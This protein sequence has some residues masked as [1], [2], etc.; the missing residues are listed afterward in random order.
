M[1]KNSGN[2]FRAA[3]AAENDQRISG[4]GGEGPAPGDGA[5]DRYAAEGQPDRGV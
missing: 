1:Q 3:A 2:S 5:P 4:G